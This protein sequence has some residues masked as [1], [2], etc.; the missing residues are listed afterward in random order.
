MKKRL[1]LVGIIL[2]RG[3]TEERNYI[4]SYTTSSGSHSYGKSRNS[5][6][7]QCVLMLGTGVNVNIWRFGGCVKKLP[8]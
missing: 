3:R 2:C 4:P 7:L 1:V 6:Q 5:S 8:R